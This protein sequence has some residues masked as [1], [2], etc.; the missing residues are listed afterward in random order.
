MIRIIIED[1]LSNSNFLKENINP[2][3]EHAY[4]VIAEVETNTKSRDVLKPKEP[5]E[6]GFEEGGELTLHEKEGT[7]HETN[8]Y[9]SNHRAFVGLNLSFLLEHCHLLQLKRRKEYQGPI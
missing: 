2:L 7:M 5:I 3:N 8:F 9:R 1:N 6:V 4:S